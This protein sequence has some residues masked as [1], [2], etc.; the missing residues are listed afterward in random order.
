M[1]LWAGANSEPA[2]GGAGSTVDARSAPLS[3]PLGLDFDGA[4]HSIGKGDSGVGATLVVVRS[5]LWGGWRSHVM[6]GFV[7]AL[8]RMRVLPSLARTRRAESAYERFVDVSQVVNAIM[9][10]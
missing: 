1:S 6:L 2:F 7:T 5:Q 3:E 10:G 9:T 8:A 4:W